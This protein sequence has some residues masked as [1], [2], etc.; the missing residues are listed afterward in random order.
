MTSLDDIL[1][2]KKNVVRVALDPDVHRFL[3]AHLKDVPRKKWAAAIA[4]LATVGLAVS[5]MANAS[6]KAV[7][8]LQ[9][10][11]TAESVSNS[12][13]GDDDQK[14]VMELV[15]MAPPS[16]QHGTP[17]RADDKA[18]STAAQQALPVATLSHRPRLHAGENARLSH[19]IELD[20]RDLDEMSALFGGR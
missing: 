13:V 20:E 19:S 8:P 4:T 17:L 3:C 7:R 15:K 18:A 11:R 9:D 10:G 12:T 2:A 16:A 1:N 5:K 6:D 14:H